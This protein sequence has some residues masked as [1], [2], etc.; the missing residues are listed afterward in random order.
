MSD[1][2]AMGSDP[3]DMALNA[4]GVDFSNSTQA[5]MFL[6]DILDDTVFQVTANQYARDFWYGVCAIISFCAILNAAQKITCQM[7]YIKSCYIR[8]SSH[9]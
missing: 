6:G 8:T 1:M 2:T 9:K 4:S 5:E 3:P 7:R